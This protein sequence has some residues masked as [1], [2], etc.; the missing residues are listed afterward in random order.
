MVAETYG[1]HVGSNPDPNKKE[2]IEFWNAMIAAGYLTDK[3]IDI[4]SYIN[5]ALFE[6]ALDAVL[7]KYPDNANYKQLKADFKK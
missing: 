7:K 2:V 3:S 4:A 1:P 5:T 6:S